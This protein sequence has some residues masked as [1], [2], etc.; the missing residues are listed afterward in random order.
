MQKKNHPTAKVWECDEATAGQIT[1]NQLEQLQQ[2]CRGQLE[3]TRTNEGGI[4]LKP[5]SE[6]AAERLRDLVSK[7]GVPFLERTAR[8]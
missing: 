5:E 8:L 7:T 3:I 4:R 6:A 1:S 2:N